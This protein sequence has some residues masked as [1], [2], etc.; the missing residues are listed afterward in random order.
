MKNTPMQKLRTHLIQNE[1]SGVI[2]K[3]LFQLIKR[4][5]CTK[6]VSFHMGRCGSTVVGRM[7]NKHPEIYWSGEVFG[8]VYKTSPSYFLKNR[9]IEYITTR[10]CSVRLEPIYGMEVNYRSNRDLSSAWLNTNIQS[11]FDEMLRLHYSKFILIHR[12]NLLRRHVSAQIAIKTKK[13][14]SKKSVSTATKTL[15][16]IH[17]LLEDKKV[18]LIEL[19]KTQTKS[20]HLVK[21]L[22][23]SQDGLLL[24]YEKHIER[25]PKSAYK[26]ICNYLDVE[27]KDEPIPLKRVNNFSLEQLIVNYQEVKN[28]LTGSEFEWM[29]KDH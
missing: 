17:S 14:H 4:S 13:F 19:F 27:V 22:V 24:E 10:D 8:K 18:D 3:T 25:N 11:F 9:N 2:L 5:K 16:P 26:L 21:K 20:Y 7:L 29:L 28:Y 15:I 23:S 12:N 6:V 1:Y